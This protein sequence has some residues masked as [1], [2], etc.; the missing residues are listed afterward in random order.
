[1][2]ARTQGAF[3]NVSEQGRGPI[4]DRALDRTDGPISKL[5]E[6]AGICIVTADG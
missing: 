2:P 3:K 6:R 5:D 1:M 4:L